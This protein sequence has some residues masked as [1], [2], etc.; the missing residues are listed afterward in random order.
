M[1]AET[2]DTGE[3]S[4]WLANDEA[5]YLAAVELGRTLDACWMS[6]KA[7]ALAFMEQFA[8]LPGVDTSAVDWFEVASDFRGS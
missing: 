2:W 4:R 5:L 3:A 1:P 8:T 7:G 6:D